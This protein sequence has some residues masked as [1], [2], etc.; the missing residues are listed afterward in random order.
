[1]P[2]HT[3]HVAY[4]LAVDAIPIPSSTKYVSGLQDHDHANE[5]RILTCLCKRQNSDHG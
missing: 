5:L 4:E 3:I 1:M 2:K